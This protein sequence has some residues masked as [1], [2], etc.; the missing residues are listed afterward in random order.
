MDPKLNIKSGLNTYKYGRLHPRSQLIALLSR[1]RVYVRAP[2]ADLNR[3]V[4]LRR[5]SAL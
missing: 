3:V 2:P 5:G 4:S 1:A